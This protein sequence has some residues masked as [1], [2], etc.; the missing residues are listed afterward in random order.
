MFFFSVGN[1]KPEKESFCKMECCEQ[2]RLTKLMIVKTYLCLGL[3]EQRT[4]LTESYYFAYA[5]YL[6]KQ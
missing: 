3:A 4:Q 6:A 1:P 5:A 2:D